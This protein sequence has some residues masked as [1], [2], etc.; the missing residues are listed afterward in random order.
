MNPLRALSGLLAR[1]VQAV[2]R[3][4]KWVMAYG[5]RFMP[6]ADAASPE[7]PIGRLLR[8]SLFQAVIGMVTTLLVG[9]LN[10]VMI[11]EL[12]IP[13]WWVAFAVGA[14]LILAPLRTVV[15]YRSDT[16]PSVLGLKRLPYLW[17]GTLLLF[18]GLSI[19]PFALLLLSD[20]TPNT[21]WIG[22][23]GMTLTFMLVGLGLQV[24]QTA[25]MALATDLA[26]E[27]KRPSVVALLHSML[28]LGMVTSSVIYGFLL[29]DFS[30][31]VLVQVIQGSAV[32]VVVFNLVSLWKQEARQARRAPREADGF[33][34]SLKRLLAQPQMV[35]FL[36]TVALGTCA[37]TMQDILIEPFGGQVLGMSV[38][39]TSSL[40]ALSAGGAFVAFALAA[41][42]LR[43][44]VHACRLAG[45]GLLLAL[46]AFVFLI[47]SVP[48]HSVPLFQS[49]A[50][51]LGFGTGLFSVGT[52]VTAMSYQDK[53]FVGLGL[54]AW[55]AVHATAGGVGAV[56]AA[57]LRDAVGHWTAQGA[58]GEVMD[59][60]A[61]GYSFVFQF[62]IYL[63]FA[64]LVAL[65]PLV[66]RVR[67]ASGMQQGR[68]VSV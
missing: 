16:H 44:G 15:G 6:F 8:L 21:L 39:Q 61:T 3:P 20:P 24:T 5:M 11:L 59:N 42:W 32:T 65:G 56:M 55:G 64:T 45:C 35:R 1:R 17:M 2:L 51:L 40:N 49:G 28:L 23:L 33:S 48:L 9:T 38:S 66:G 25:G 14:P 62:E 12:G 7:L 37:L 47:F 27:E 63:V 18:G 34:R 68:F 52:L 50:C 36:W 31:K 13:A 4:P 41:M 58:M 46:P 54:G 10:R 53:E 22:R 57:L 43:Q 29:Q 30:P 60:V 26:T 19:M 67:R